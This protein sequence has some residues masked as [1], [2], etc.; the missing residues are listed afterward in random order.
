MNGVQTVVVFR[1]NPYGGL[2]MI[3]SPIV[4]KDARAAV[5]QEPP[6]EAPAATPKK[7]PIRLLPKF[8]D[9]VTAFASSKLRCGFRTARKPS[10]VR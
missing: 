8:G 9:T 6:E 1:K 4:G 7:K 5:G 3:S 2:T 10:L